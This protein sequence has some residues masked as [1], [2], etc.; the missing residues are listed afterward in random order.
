MAL[1]SLPKA[2]NATLSLVAVARLPSNASV[3]LWLVD[4]ATLSWNAAALL[5][6]VAV[7]RLP[8]S[9]PAKLSLTATARL[10]SSAYAWLPL[11]A[12]AWEVASEEQMLSPLSTLVLPLML[13]HTSAPPRA[14]SCARAAPHRATINASIMVVAPSTD[15]FILNTS[16]FLLPQG[17]D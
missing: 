11:T 17:R 8:P 4:L 1:A 3:S 16:S 5:W 2:A 14:S 6:L 13:T 7:A 15:S 12:T 9:A 10:P